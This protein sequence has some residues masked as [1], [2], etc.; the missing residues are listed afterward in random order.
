MVA[1]MCSYVAGN[2]QVFATIYEA[3]AP[4]VRRQIQS[5]LGPDALL[6]DLVQ[7]T[8]LRAHAARRRFAP[9]RLRGSEGV[10]SWYCAIARNAAISELRRRYGTAGATRT[11]AMPVSEELPCQ[12]PDAECT[13]I[14]DQARRHAHEVVHSSLAA[15][16]EHQ[17]RVVQMHKLEE[18]PMREVARQ[19]GIR[20]GAARVR[21]HRAYRM[22]A[23]RAGVLPSEEG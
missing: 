13:A 5:V 6:D 17:R 23:Q 7:D 16:P 11:W 19:L 1:S 4:K 20:P 21:A 12:Q 15:L 18:L 10:V 14:A 9:E 2:D 8:F 22:M 3:L